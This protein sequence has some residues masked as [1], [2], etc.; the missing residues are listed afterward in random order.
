MGTGLQFPRQLR[1]LFEQG[2]RLARRREQLDLRQFQQQFVALDQS[3]DFLLR[4]RPL[5]NRDNQRLLEGIGLQ[6]DRYNLLRFLEDPQVEPTNNRAERALRPA[7]IRRKVSQC[8]KTEAGARTFEA[9]L[10]VIQTFKQQSPFT[11]S[12]SLLNLFTAPV[13]LLPP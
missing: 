1:E 5:R 7:V 6:H 3:L 13:P 12:Q 8:S 9:F 10:S 11:V 2:L 4:D